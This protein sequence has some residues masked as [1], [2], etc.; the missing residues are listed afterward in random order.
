M[1]YRTWIF[2]LNVDGDPGDPEAFCPVDLNKEKIREYKK[3]VEPLK[4]NDNSKYINKNFLIEELF[5][6]GRL[7][8]GWGSEHDGHNLDLRQDEKVWYENYIMLSHRIWNEND[9]YCEDAVGRR[10]ILAQMLEME[11]GNLIFVPKI[12]DDSKFTVVKVKSKYYFRVP[13]KKCVH[14]HVIEVGELRTFTYE[15]NNMECG[16]SAIKF[17]PYRRAINEV[18]DIDFLHCL[19]SFLRKKKIV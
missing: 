16:L 4:N 19:D 2:R 8:Q 1:S 11:K 18:K 3:K 12:P 7:R 13:P 15:N 10:N 17:R 6:H 9:V 14:G 5:E